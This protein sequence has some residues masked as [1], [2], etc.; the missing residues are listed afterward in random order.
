LALSVATL[1]TTT[2]VRADIFGSGGNAFTIDFVTIGNPGNPVDTG[3]TGNYFSS[4]G[5]VGTTFQMG[6]YEISEDMINKANTLGGLLITRDTRG[7]NKAATGVSWNE[8]ARFVNWLNVS[9]GSSAAYKFAVQPGG[10]GYTGNEN[11][12]L[13]TVSDAGYDAG[14]LYRNKKA[15]YF[16]P[17]ENEWYKAA[18]YSGSGTTY[19]DCGGE[20]DGSRECGLRA[21]FCDG[22]SGHHASWWTECLRDDGAERECVGME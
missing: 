8:A 16:L 11:L 17:S 1:L 14:N 13:W 7:V 9:S 10:G 22:P 15:R 21:D 6:K 20:R 12:V 19:F 3:T 5:G 2:S 18:F 4:Y